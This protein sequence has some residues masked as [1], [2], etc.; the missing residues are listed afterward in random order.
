MLFQWI[1]W[2][3]IVERCAKQYK[4]PAAIYAANENGK[5]NTMQHLK[6]KNK[7]IK[8]HVCMCVCVCLYACVCV[9]VW[10]HPC[11]KA[12]CAVKDSQIVI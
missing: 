8:W 6:K 12:L 7:P 10:S 3:S 5:C 2:A 4:E 11:H 1:Q 9:C